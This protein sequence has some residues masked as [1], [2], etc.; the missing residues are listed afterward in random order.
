V[1]I[2]YP[3]AER[4]FLEDSLPPDPS[5]DRGGTARLLR[6]R[7]EEIAGALAALVADW[8]KYADQ[9]ADDPAAF[10]QLETCS[11]V[12]YVARLIESGDAN[13]RHLYI[14]EKVKQFYD[15]SATA[16]MRLQRE[17]A[18]L[19]GERDIFLGALADPAARRI[20]EMSFDAIEHA[21]TGEA[22]AEVKALFIGD[23]LY[24]DLISFLTAP[25][26][27]D[28]VRLRP[29]FVTAHDPAE[30]R[31]QVA[32]LA[33]DRF[34]VI[35]YSP[36][37]YAMLSDYE[38]L[39][40]PRGLLDRAGMKK[41]AKS[42]VSEGLA[43]FDMLADLF[44]CPIV[45]HAPAP[46]LRSE[47]TLKESIVAALTRP[48]LQRT[49]SNLGQALR[50]RAAERNAQGR[51]IHILD[52]A[53]IIGPGG[54]RQAGRYLFHSDRQH[55][56]AFGAM[57]AP[58]YRDIV[59]VV[60]RLLKRK[61]VVCDL[62]NT[63]WRGVI[64]E[65]LG[66][67]HHYDRQAPLLTLKQ[68]GV[69]LAINSKNDPAKAI[70]QAEAGRLA[71]DHFV[72]RQINWDPK[73]INM[74]RI[75]EHLNLNDK[76]FAFI[77]DRADER[78]MVE[79]QFPAI[80]ALDA[81]DPRSW[82]L[83]VLWANLL[84]QKPGADRTEFY[85]QRDERRKF[86]AAETEMDVQ[87]RD[88]MMAQLGLKLVVREATDRDVDRVTDLINRTNQF[89]MTASRATRPQ[90]QKWASSHDAQMLVAD[91]SDRFGAMGT[92]SV[93]VIERSHTGVSIPAFVLS[94]RVFGYGMEFA[95]L[96]QA[97]RFTRAGEALFGPLVETS[98]NQPCREVYPAADFHAID[99]GWQLDHPATAV[100]KVPVWLKIK[101]DISLPQIPATPKTRAITSPT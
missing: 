1:S 45:A 2:P 90:V 71:L 59:M 18:L 46:I 60:G 17:A 4:I 84:A 51:V 72:S 16:E 36:F 63:L 82:R 55:P 33:D 30:V 69:L 66:V 80:L 23:C 87:Q 8:P 48:A 74:R 29:G 52:E 28:G 56:A 54:L 92:I 5:F 89:N 49:A 85:R 101:C 61:V 43:I 35:F 15:P 6:R 41:H 83:F 50:K 100:I 86:V 34:D 31:G 57:L 25:A 39:Q 42:A 70:W 9:Y 38:A 53:A 47:G 78:A 81:L 27:A 88:A 97:L 19:A 91:A 32:K 44:D 95:I 93:L 24:L 58:I 94:C 99:G 12:E 26:L 40:R 21:L 10:A 22:V 37:T 67:E 68:R 14:G 3:S 65:G 20:I 79:A 7:V 98:F 76:D 64:G 77:D 13:F 62:D 75:A 96:A 73:A 11:L